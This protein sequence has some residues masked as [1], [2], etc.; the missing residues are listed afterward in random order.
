MDGS[1]EEDAKTPA[2]YDYNIEGHT[3]SAR[4]PISSGSRSR[5]SGL[6]GVARDRPAGEEDGVGAEGALTHDM[7]LTDPAQAKDFVARTGVDALA[8]AS[9]RV[10]APTSSRVNPRATYSILTGSADP[11]AVPNTHS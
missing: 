10:M 5:G 6:L 1:L 11:A 4:W 8:I 3:A 2:S 7:M 9:E